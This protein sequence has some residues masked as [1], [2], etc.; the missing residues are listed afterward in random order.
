MSTFIVH[1]TIIFWMKIWIER[2]MTY[3]HYE[4]F[5]IFYCFID[6]FPSSNMVKYITE[7]K[8]YSITFIFVSLDK[9]IHLATQKN[10]IRTRTIVNQY[11]SLSQ[12]LTKCWEISI[13]RKA[14]LISLIAAQPTLSN[15]I[16][17]RDLF[18]LSAYKY[19]LTQIH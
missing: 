14:R 12:V 13:T 11:S 18:F 4:L 1:L 3:V 19:I 7:W 6:F 17:T 9:L 10:K 15:L 8:F 2:T 5:R 16:K